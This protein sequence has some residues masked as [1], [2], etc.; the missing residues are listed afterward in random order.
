[1][2]VMGEQ[3]NP[4]STRTPVRSRPTRAATAEAAELLAGTTLAQHC[5]EV[6]GV[7]GGGGEPLGMAA[8][9]V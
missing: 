7:T 2:T 8:A 4:T 1:M 3:L 9:R 5:G 6:G